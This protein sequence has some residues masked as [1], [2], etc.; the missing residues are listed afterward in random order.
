[1]AEERALNHYQRKSLPTE[2][3]KVI[4]SKVTHL[5]GKDEFA[6][7]VSAHLKFPC[8]KQEG[9]A[10]LSIDEIRCIVEARLRII[11]VCKTWYI[12]GIAD[13]YSHVWFNLGSS[14]S[15]SIH[16]LLA[17]NPSALLYVKR[18]TVPAPAQHLED[19]YNTLIERMERAVTIISSLPRIRILHVSPEVAAML[20][21][22]KL[23]PTLDVVTILQSPNGSNLPILRHSISATVVEHVRV[24]FLD[25]AIF[26]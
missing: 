4:L 17:K 13:L 20:L 21:T 11:L 3:W 14:K 22:K 25:P 18:L 7:E 23:A 26:H 8:T 24:L 6:T 1:M 12:F 10:S 15:D 16:L 5:P 19:E 2:L 9:S